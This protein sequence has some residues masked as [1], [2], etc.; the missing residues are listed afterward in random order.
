MNYSEQLKQK[1]TKLITLKAQASA[2]KQ[3]IEEMLEKRKK[4][5]DE[6]K[7]KFGITLSEVPDK[8]VE[9]QKNLKELCEKLSLEV[10]EIESEFAKIKC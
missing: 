6:V 3:S 5:E 4:A 2:K 7:S 8:L 9:Y 10:D 1:E